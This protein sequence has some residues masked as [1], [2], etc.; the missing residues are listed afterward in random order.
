M[1]SEA[2]S[3]VNN[4][5]KIAAP[6]LPNTTGQATIK[7]TRNPF[8]SNRNGMLITLLRT[9]PGLTR[10]RAGEGAAGSVPGFVARNHVLTCGLV[11]KN[12]IT[13]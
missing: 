8:P 11:R 9:R 2:S 7:K 5:E 4:V 3:R 10:S 12:R 1:T 13:R 6:M